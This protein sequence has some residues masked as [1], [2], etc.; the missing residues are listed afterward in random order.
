MKKYF[1]LLLVLLLG[2]S[3]I[4]ADWVDKAY[5]FMSHPAV[6]IVSAGLLV[7]YAVELATGMAP[8][9]SL[10]LDLLNCEGITLGPFILIDDDLSPASREIVISHEKIHVMQF[11]EIGIF[12]FVVPYTIEVFLNGIYYD[13][14]WE[15]MAYR[16]QKK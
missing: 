15:R 8:I 1:L 5:S 10:D 2:I 13:N 6:R 4:A 3:F 7:V 16:Y 11:A 14:F 9:F 12:A